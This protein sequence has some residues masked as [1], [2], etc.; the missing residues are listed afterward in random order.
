MT[1]DSALRELVDDV[2]YKLRV[3]ADNP[4][5]HGGQPG[6]IV[7]MSEQ[8]GRLES[9]LAAAASQQPAP[10][11]MVLVPRELLDSVLSRDGG[12]ACACI[13]LSRKA[14]REYEAGECPHQRLATHL[15]AAPTALP[16]T[17][18]EAFDQVGV[19]MRREVLGD[20]AP[21]AQVA[22]PNGKLVGWWNGIMPDVTGRSLQEPSVRWGKDGE[23][24]RHDIPLYDGYNPIHYQAPTAPAAPAVVV[25]EAMVERLVRTL[26]P[27][28]IRPDGISKGVLLRAKIALAAALKGD[29]S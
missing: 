13:G 26:W 19:A 17:L 18:N 25:D 7:V 10:A 29:A 14:E 8:A 28:K 2:A 9:I 21:A 12:K 15:A 3:A 22:E 5:A 16:P 27:N 4:S 6:L 11:G 20:A 23:N 1:T 24:S